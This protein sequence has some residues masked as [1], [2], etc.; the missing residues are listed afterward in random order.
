V[1]DPDDKEFIKQMQMGGIPMNFTTPPLPFHR[2]NYKSYLEQSDRGHADLL[3]QVAAG[4]VEGPLHYIPRVVSPQGGIYNPVK[5]KWRTTHDL[6]ASGVNPCIAPHECRYDLMDGVVA[7]MTPSGWQ[8]GWDLTDAFFNC[9]RL[10]QHCDY[11]GLECGVTGEFYRHRWSVFGGTDCPWIQQRFG[12]IL[13]KT[14]NQQGLLLPPAAGWPDTTIIGVFLDDAHG[15][16]DASLS[17]PEATK[18]FGNM[19]EYMSALGVQDAVKKRVWPCKSKAYIGHVINSVEQTVVA[20]PAKIDSCHLAEQACWQDSKAN[21]GWVH[22]RLWASFI[23]KLQN[24]APR[25]VGGQGMLTWAYQDRDSLGEVTGNPWDDVVMVKV[26]AQTW[27]MVRKLLALLPAG[28]TKY[29]LDGSPE[30]NGF[31]KGITDYT[32]AEMD[33]LH[34]AG[35]D[36]PVITTDAS[37]TAGGR[38]LY[39]S[40]KIKQYPPELSAP[41]KSSNYRELDMVVEGVTDPDWLVA[42]AKQRLLVRIDNSTSVSIVNRQGTMAPELW[43]LSAE[44]C[45]FCRKH[46]IDIAA[47]HIPGL[48][49][50]LADRLS[51]WEWERDAANWQL[52]ADIILGAW[53]RTGLAQWFTLDGGADP[54]G[55]N[56][57]CKRFRS[58]VDSFFDHHVGGEDLWLNPDFDILEEV[59]VHIKKC[60]DDRPFDTSAT[61]LAPFW[62]AS[63]VSKLRGGKVVAF[64]PANTPAFTS[65][66][67]FH[68]QGD[69]QADLSVLPR[70]YRGP[71]QWPSV[72][73]HFPPVL[74]H[75]GAGV[76]LPGLEH[77]LHQIRGLPTLTGHYAQD[78]AMLQ[79]LPAHD[80]V[81]LR[82]RGRDMVVPAGATSGLHHRLGTDQKPPRAGDRAPGAPG[83]GHV[84]VPRPTRAGP[85]HSAGSEQAR[86]AILD[87]QE[88]FRARELVCDRILQPGCGEL[89]GGSEAAIPPPGDGCLEVAD[90]ADIIQIE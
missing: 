34:S 5:D 52:D 33:V 12:E 63:Y 51:R 35:R 10:Q 43:G 29:Y 4:F 65:P 15:V 87:S 32:H 24:L 61:V 80:L 9:P 72:I 7:I 18:Q 84:P 59:L 42:Y 79:A 48:I 40:R 16:Q 46:E 8:V 74:P 62:N 2:R 64:I 57:F 81:R 45:D 1:Q 20:E 82:Q 55:S 38:Y 28:A 27:A 21:Q 39:D 25:V 22:R 19:L 54:V 30:Q 56:A 37:G 90:A 23:G 11:L 88:S 69:P 83:V 13:K 73:V 41:I 67:W 31:W 49:N 17:L 6:T 68:L 44:L 85:R 50:Y 77:R 71:T 58:V 89:M 76:P 86:Q 70:V 66:D 60:M 78:L 75:G 14:L 26:R 53:E 47:V 36:I 3:R